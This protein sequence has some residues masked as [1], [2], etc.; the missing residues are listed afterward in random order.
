M[1]VRNIMQYTEKQDNLAK[2]LLAKDSRKPIIYSLSKNTE[3]TIES[4]KTRFLDEEVITNKK[5]R[6]L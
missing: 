2:N 4:S 3:S 1:G 6:N 5:S